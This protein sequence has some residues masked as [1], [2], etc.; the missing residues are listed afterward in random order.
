[1]DTAVLREGSLT[2]LLGVPTTGRSPVGVGRKQRKRGKRGGVGEKKGKGK[3]RGER[4][5]E[6]SKERGKRQSSGAD[7]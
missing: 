2:L 3:K 5:K 7:G 1:M 6:K 4:R